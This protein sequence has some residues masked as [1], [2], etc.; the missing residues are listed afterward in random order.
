VLLPRSGDDATAKVP[1]T[2]LKPQ[3]LVLMCAVPGQRHK[4]LDNR[5]PQLYVA[6]G[7]VGKRETSEL[8]R[9]R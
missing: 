9:S 2:N 6:V 3:S 7:H 1:D 4:D 8:V 5:N